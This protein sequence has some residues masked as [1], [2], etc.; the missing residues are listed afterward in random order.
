MLLVGISSRVDADSGGCRRDVLLGALP[1]PVPP[2]GRD[3]A[4]SCSSWCCTDGTQGREDTSSCLLPMQVGQACFGHTQTA[5]TSP[6]PTWS[7][8]SC[9]EM[10][11]S[12]CD[13]CGGRQTQAFLVQSGS[14][15]VYSG[16]NG[17]SASG[18]D[19]KLETPHSRNWDQSCSTPGKACLSPAPV[20]LS[21]ASSAILLLIPPGSWPGH[22]ERAALPR[23]VHSWRA[24]W[25]T[26]RPRE[27][28]GKGRW[29]ARHGSDTCL[30][31]IH[32]R[33]CSGLPRQALE[34]LQ[35]LLPCTSP[36][37]LRGCLSRT[38]PSPP[39]QQVPS[40][41]L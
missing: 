40:R 12:T 1:C 23:R 18:E 27:G 32:T 15:P 41:H 19:T 8:P 11:A 21:S 31:C 34:L 33:G 29:A 16:Q 35:P 39:L 24:G 4:G 9:S 5:N 22:P 3:G 17:L 2:A 6:A 36:G 25:H 7:S 13:L 26:A 38:T 28:P 37:L 30:P 10:N 14:A 20:C